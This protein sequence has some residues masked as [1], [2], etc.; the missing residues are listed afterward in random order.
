MKVDLRVAKVLT[1]EKVPNSRK[2]MKL[3]IDVG[4]E[5]RTLVAGIAEAYEPEQLVGR[6]I[7][8]VVQPQAGQADGHRVE[9]HGAGRQPRRRQADAGRLRQDIAARGQRFG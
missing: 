3:T 6:T 2:L 4:T 1:A 9:R 8:M 7:V 5:Q